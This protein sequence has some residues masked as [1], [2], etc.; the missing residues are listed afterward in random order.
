[1]RTLTFIL[2]LLFSTT[3]LLGQ[4]ASKQVK[5]DSI[6]HKFRQCEDCPVLSDTIIYKL[7]KCGLYFGSNGDIAYRTEE[8]YNDNFDKRTRYINWVYGADITDTVNGGLKEMKYVIDTTTFKFLSVLYWA[9]DK[10]I[11]GFTPM[12]DGGTVYFSDIADRKTFVVLDGSGYAKD[13]AN[14]Y[15]RGTIIQ[16]ADLKTFKSVKHK[17]ITELACDS[18][19]FYQTG[20]RLTEKEVEEFSLKKIRRN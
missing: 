5:T 14:V 10:N 7:L 9:D 20:H 17:E 18:L 11:Y 19:Y 16:G 15:Y 6:I 12:S 4:P 13:K 2:T 1:M 8:V 3:L